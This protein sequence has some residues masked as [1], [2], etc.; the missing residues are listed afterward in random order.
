MVINVYAEIA[1]E[2]KILIEKFGI[3]HVHI[4]KIKHGDTIIC[5][6]GSVRTVNGL[7]IRNNYFIGTTLY[8]DSYNLGTILVPRIKTN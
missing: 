7:F 1:V 5:K 2:D 8:G 3:E 6:D 4:N